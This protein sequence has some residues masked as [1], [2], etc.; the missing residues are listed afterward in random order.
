MAVRPIRNEREALKILKRV[1]ESASASQRVDFGALSFGPQ[2]AFIEDDRRFLTAT[3]G[4]RAGKTDGMALKALKAAHLYPGSQIPYITNNRPQAK[5]NFWPK[6]LLWNRKLNLNAKFNV[7]ELTMTLPNG[8]MIM[9]GGANDEA[10]IERWR[11][12]AYP[13]VIIDEAQSIRGFLKTL[14]EEILAPAT[15]DYAGQIVMI[16]TPNATAAGYFHDCNTGVIVDEDTGEPLWGAHHWTAFDNPNI[17]VPYREGRSKDVKR[18][19][20]DAYDQIHTLRKLQGLD[21]KDPKFLRETMGQWVRDEEGLVYRIPDRAIIPTLP[22]GTWSYVLGVDVGYVDATAFVVL[23]YNAEK[24]QIVVADSYQRTEMIPSA[25]AAEVDRL[26]ERW[27]IESVVVDP[28]GGGK[29]YVEEMKQKYGLPAKVAK[30]QQKDVNIDMLNGDLRAGVMQI[31]GPRN[32]ELLEDARLLQYDYTKADRRLGP[33]DANG[34]RKVNVDRSMRKIDDRTPDH[35]LDAMLYGYRECKA[36]YD[37]EI[38]GPTPGTEAWWAQEEA[39][40][41]ERARRKAGRHEPDQA[42]WER[43]F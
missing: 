39:E 31:V 37:P 6:L 20:Q 14:V 8:S 21:I 15:L 34:K 25:V 30:K 19:L 7:V 23:A 33:P 36:L 2:R 28:G 43:G 11:G 17:S 40:L 3:C 32:V 12:S 22:P 4:R 38:L 35:L 27:D 18:A 16:G 41:L 13:L 29:A 26:V 5:R 24:M 1:K 10:E 42:W 9:L